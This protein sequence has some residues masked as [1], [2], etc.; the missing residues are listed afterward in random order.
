VGAGN[1]RLQRRTWPARG[2]VPPLAV[3]PVSDQ[4]D[5]AVASLRLGLDVAD[6]LVRF[7]LPAVVAEITTGS[8]DVSAGPNDP[9][10][11]RPVVDPPRVARRTRIP[12]QQDTGVTV[13]EGLP[14]GVLARHRPTGVQSDMAV[15]VDQTGQYPTFGDRLRARH[16]LE[17]DTTLTYPEVAVLPLR[18]HDPP[19]MQGFDGH[20][21]AP[22]QV[23]G[24]VVGELHG[25]R[26][27]LSPAAAAE[28]GRELARLRHHLS[29]S[30][31]GFRG[32]EF[33]RSLGRV[34]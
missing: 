24:D 30:G 6:E 34:A 4:L 33:G 29:V 5:P 32:G 2:K 10:Q 7:D 9:G 14:L 31:R 17:C 19:D 12:N 11:V 8:G 20:P 22:L 13:R 27:E 16:G 3:D 23:L 25:G 26:V 18:Q 21:S 28:G 1:G 15:Q